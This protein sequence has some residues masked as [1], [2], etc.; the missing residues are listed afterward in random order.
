MVSDGYEGMADVPALLD[1]LN[2]AR[3]DLVLLGLGDP[4][5][6]CWFLEHRHRLPPAV[7]AGV[8]A[9]FDF[10]SGSVPRAPRVFRVMGLEWF[11]RLAREPGRMWRRYSLDGMRF[12]WLCW[13]ERRTAAGSCRLDGAG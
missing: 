3:P 2:Q 8:G 7:Y 10:H 11:Y 1:R 13:R 6:G 9:L 12:A 5:Q 4:R